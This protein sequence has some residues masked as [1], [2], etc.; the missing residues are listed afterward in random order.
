MAIAIGKVAAALER[1]TAA[2]PCGR[3]AKVFGGDHDREQ[4][5][6]DL[7]HR[8]AVLCPCQNGSDRADEREAPRGP[9]RRPGS[10][11]GRQSVSATGSPPARL[12]SAGMSSFAAYETN[13]TLPSASAKFAPPG[14][15]LQKWNIPH[16]S[17]N[18]DGRYG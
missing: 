8:V 5:V 6:A 11:P 12:A 7:P 13:R 17:S 16:W 1:L 3:C 10:T 9:S 15:G 4:A 2:R 14:C 18:R